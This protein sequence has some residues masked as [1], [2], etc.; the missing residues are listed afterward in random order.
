SAFDTSSAVCFRSPLSTLPSRVRSPRFRNPPHQ[1]S[2][3]QQLS[4]ALDLHPTARLERAPFLSPSSL[5]PRS[6]TPRSCHTPPTRP[7]APNRT[8]ERAGRTRLQN[9]RLTSSARAPLVLSAAAQDDPRSL[10]SGPAIV[11][12]SYWWVLRLP[13]VSELLACACLARLAGRMFHLAI[14]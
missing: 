4:V 11:T 6:P 3:R 7:P 5:H 1:R 12:I 13:Q 9:P 2:L 10:N 8:P 14:I